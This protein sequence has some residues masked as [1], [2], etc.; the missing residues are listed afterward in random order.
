MPDIRAGR[1]E[2]GKEDKTSHSAKTSKPAF[3]AP[4]PDR[5]TAYPPSLAI[6]VMTCAPAG[7]L[8]INPEK[9]NSGVSANGEG[10]TVCKPVKRVSKCPHL[11]EVFTY[12]KLYLT[13]LMKG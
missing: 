2:I 10:A 3:A 12:K 6:K 1:P 5:L 7:R 4:V 8:C 9:S 13:S 11:V